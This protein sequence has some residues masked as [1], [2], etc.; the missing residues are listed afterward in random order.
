MQKK[1]PVNIVPVKEGD[2]EFLWKLAN[3]TEVRAVS[4][5]TDAIKW[6]DHIKWLKSKL[7]S[8]S[9]LFY[10]AYNSENFPVGQVRYDITNNE[11]V[12]SI[13]LVKEFR[14]KGY[15]STMIKVS[16]ERLFKLTN[17]V[18]IH[19]YIKP[20]NIASIFAFLKA[21]FKTIRLIT[22]QNQKVIDLIL[23]R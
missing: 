1:Q 7:N 21:D 6:E 3:D 22:Y 18:K 4:F 8:Q 23:D 15:G 17:V 9:C 12:I 2:A 5:S 13:S 14:G 16:V 10:I 19:A 11:A 20:T